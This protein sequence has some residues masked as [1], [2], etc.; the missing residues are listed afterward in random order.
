MNLCEKIPHVGLPTSSTFITNAIESSSSTSPRPIKRTER[1]IPTNANKSI[2]YDR[3]TPTRLCS[4]SL[5]RTALATPRMPSMLRTTRPAFS[6]SSDTTVNCSYCAIA[7]PCCLTPSVPFDSLGRTSFA[8]HSL[9]PTRRILSRED[10]FQKEDNTFND[11]RF[12]EAAILYN[13]GA[14]YSRLGANEPRRTHEVTP[15]CPPAS[16]ISFFRS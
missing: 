12:E 7:F 6:F 4:L 1:N 10:G 8:M 2:V 5:S 11:V 3:Y 16:C 13:I 15:L 14:L 9:I